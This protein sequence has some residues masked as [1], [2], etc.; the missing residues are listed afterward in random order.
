MYL[1]VI[2]CINL[3]TCD[4]IRLGLGL[5]GEGK[6]N[7]QLLIKVIIGSFDCIILVYLSINLANDLWCTR[8]GFG[9]GSGEAVLP[10]SSSCH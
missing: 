5:G 7:G 1:S 3:T 9:G 6:H 4:V 2:S 8:L 10:S